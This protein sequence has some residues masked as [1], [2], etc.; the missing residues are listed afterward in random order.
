MPYLEH[1]AESGK[2]RNG[3]VYYALIFLSFGRELKNITIIKFKNP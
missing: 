2:R 1:Y 3:F